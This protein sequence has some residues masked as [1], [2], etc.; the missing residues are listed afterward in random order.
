LSRG[1][2]VFLLVAGALTALALWGIPVLKRKF[3]GE[4][5]QVRA[6]VL[7]AFEDPEVKVGN[8]LVRRNIVDLEI[9]FPMGSAPSTVRELQ[10]ED[11]DGRIVDV[12]WSNNPDREDN[13]DKGVTRWVV[14][15]AFFPVEFRQGNLRNKVRV[16]TYIRMPPLPY[17]ASPAH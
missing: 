4:S 3:M 16:L 8:E 17:N 1:L 13:E 9:L 10:I 12:Y 15:E 5:L 11:D 2:F 7:R 14:R 6:Q